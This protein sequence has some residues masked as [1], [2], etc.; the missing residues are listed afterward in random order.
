M[1]GEDL[2]PG[3]QMVIVSL[4]PYRGR[5]RGKGREGERKEGKG[6]ERE[7]TPLSCLLRVLIPFMRVPPS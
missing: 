6:I 2:L 3:F 7:N 4:Y 1:S 5:R